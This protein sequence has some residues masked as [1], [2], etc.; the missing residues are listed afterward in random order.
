GFR[1]REEGRV[2]LEFWGDTVEEIRWCKV[3][4]QR[5]LEAAQDGLCAPPCRELLPTPEVRERARE[6]AEEF[7]ALAEV[8]DQ[9]AEGTPVEGMEAFAPA[10]AGEMDLLIDHLPARS[11]VFVCDPERIRGRAEE[12]VRTS[13]EFLEASWINAAAGGEAPID[14]GAAA[15][16]TLDEIREHAGALG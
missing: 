15:F 13:Q 16:R 2:R 11:A 14:L 4:D 10:L 7:P 9:M 8:L 1:G 3:A 6:L 12:L 5:S